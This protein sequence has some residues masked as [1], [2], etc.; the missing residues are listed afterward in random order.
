MTGS[1]QEKNGKYYAVLNIADGSG[2]RA[3]QKWICTGYTV[4]GNKK[5]AEQFLREQLQAYDEKSGLVYT[6]MLFS[7]AVREWLKA[8]EI[9]IDAV[10][11]QG[12]I[13]LADRH[14]LPY[15]DVMKVKLV[16]VDR[17]MLQKYIDEKY[18][19]GRL[20]GKGGLSPASMK[21]HKNILYQTLKAAVRDDMIHKNPCEF[22]TL[23]QMQRHDSKFMTA[24]KLNEFLEVIKD[25]PIYP[26]IKVTSVYGLRRSE[27]VGLKWDSVDFDR[28][29]L[30]IKHTVV[31]VSETIEKD[32][33]KNASSYRS[34]PLTDEIKS[35]LL[36]IKEQEK[37]NKKL[38]GKEYFESDYIFR[39]DDGRPISP[40][41]VSHRFGKLLKEKGFPHI[42]FH[43][44]RHSC[45]SMLIT[46]GFTLKDVQEWLG[47]SDIKMTA[48][49]Y[50]HI[51]VTRKKGMAD[52]ISA[53]LNVK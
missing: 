21:L 50:S 24:E 19:H 5:K 15:F 48:N 7:D 46:M 16:D 8:S 38:F 3:K 25:E 26:M 44:I 9:R 43:E 23:P 10:T 30:T 53:A 20:D 49:I 17:K 32:K 6:D 45:A 37:E 33:T 35:M 27:L 51:D 2:K 22:V 12:Y 11:M 1:L 41:Y 40:D 13:A 36:K 31:K 39:W 42:R 28:N 14:I 47:H 52:T 29:T 34:F 4:K 18:R